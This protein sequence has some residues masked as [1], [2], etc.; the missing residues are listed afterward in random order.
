MSW[1]AVWDAF[2]AIGTVAMAVTTVLVIRQGKQQHR[3]VFRPICV[4]VPDNGFDRFGRQ[5]ILEC[6][7]ERGA[8]GK[9]YRVRAAIRNIGGGP[10]LNLRLIVRFAQRPDIALPCEL[11]PVGANEQDDSPIKVPVFLGDQF[12]RMD[13]EIGPG[14]VWELWLECEDIFGRKFRSRHT[15]NPQ[16]PWTRLE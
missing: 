16:E 2:T 13:Y 8:S 4:L 6:L 14:D 9:F 3:D 12:N 7:D 10:A 1:P 5:G 11:P 15:K